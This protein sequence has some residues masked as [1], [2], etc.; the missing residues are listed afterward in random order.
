VP[1]R[2]ECDGV[3]LADALAGLRAAPEPSALPLWLDL[4]PSRL[5]LDARRRSVRPERLIGPW[6]RALAAGAC[7]VPV[8]GVLVGRDATLTIRPLAA[9]AAAATLA[10]LLRAWREG[11]EAPL[12]VA[13]RT[14]LASLGRAG[15]VAA[16]YEGG[17]YQR[18]EVEEPCLARAYPDF[19]ALDAQGRFAGCAARLYGPLLQWIEDQVTLQP[20]AAATVPEAAAGSDD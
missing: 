3:V 5:C 7:G 16:V 20:H 14:A 19:E 4:L 9:A 18:G 15:D 1:L 17:P 10:A 2:F 13:L 12:P 11:M 6:V 8:Q